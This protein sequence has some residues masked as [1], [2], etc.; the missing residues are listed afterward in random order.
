MFLQPK[1]Q[2]P[3]VLGRTGKKSSSSGGNA[4]G[5]PARNSETRLPTELHPNPSFSYFFFPSMHHPY[6]HWEAK[7]Q[8]LLV[9]II[10]LPSRYTGLN[11]QLFLALLPSQLELDEEEPPLLPA[12]HPSPLGFPRCRAR[13]DLQRQDQPISLLRPAALIDCGQDPTLTS[14]NRPRP[15]VMPR[16]PGQAAEMLTRFPQPY[17]KAPAACARLQLQG[18]EQLAWP[19]SPNSSPKSLVHPPALESSSGAEELRGR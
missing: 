10:Q 19:T 13:S 17:R 1:Q 14:P 7:L 11:H 6:L 12:L 8:R 15:G 2:L 5:F 3:R 9:I 4:L 18:W 16:A